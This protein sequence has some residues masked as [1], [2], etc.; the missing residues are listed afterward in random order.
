M[1]SIERIHQ[2]RPNGAL[3]S[4]L[5]G[6]IRQMKSSHGLT[7]NDLAKAFGLSSGMVAAI[8]RAENPANLRTARVP[9]I[10]A[11]MDTIEAG[12]PFPLSAR[13]YGGGSP[14]VGTHTLGELVARV[15]ALG[16]SVTFAPLRA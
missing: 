14:N 8:S 15:N 4:E 3:G 11:A 1:S 16:F 13:P 9:T 12:R 5:R 7:Y 6:R 10:L 2:D